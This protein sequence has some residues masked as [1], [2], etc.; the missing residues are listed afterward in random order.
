MLRAFLL[1]SLLSMG[2][3]AWTQ[4]GDVQGQLRSGGSPVAYAVVAIAGTTEATNADSTGHFRLTQVPVGAL[5]LVVMAIG[6]ETIHWKGQV[7]S[8]TPQTIF[9]EMLA[10]P[11]SMS[12]VVVTGTLKSVSKSECPLPIEI[13]SSSFFKKNP[14]ASLFES[15]QNINGVR[16]QNNCN[17]CN[18]GDIHINGLE[19]AYTLVLIDG[20]PLVSSLGSVY[21]LFGI[22]RSLIERVEVVRGPAAAL[23]GSESM[24][25][26][27]NVITKRPEAAPKWSMEFNGGTW[28]D[29]QLDLGHAAA[30]GKKWSV[31]T[32]LNYFGFDERVD[33][34]GDGFTDV[35]LQSRISVFQKWRM[36]RK[37]NR[38]FS[39]SARYYY[40]DRW[41]GEVEWQRKDRGRDTYYGESIYTNRWEC[42]GVYQLPIKEKIM[43]Q[44]SYIEHQQNS[45]Y[46]LTHF[47][48]H[49]R[50][51]LGQLTW[52]KKIG[53]WDGL[54]GVSNRYT[55][56][57]DNTTVT[58]NGD[59][60]CPINQPSIQIL[61]GVFAQTEWLK[62]ASHRL[63]LGA[64]LDYHALHG[65]IFTPR[66]AHKW[67]LP[68]K[69]ILRFNIGSGFRVVNVF[70]E[71]HAALTGARNVVV[72]SDL[73][74][75]RSTNASIAFATAYK[76]ASGL[77]ITIDLNVFYTYFQ[78]RILPDYIT[79]ANAIFYN[80]LNGHADNKGINLSV[81]GSWRD[82]WRFN[83]GITWNESATYTWHNDVLEKL[84]PFFNE[85]FAGAWSITYVSKKWPLTIDYTGNVYSPMLLPLLGPLDPRSGQSPWWSIQN[86]QMTYKSGRHW[87]WFGGVK[88]LL[89]WTPLGDNPFLI[90]LSHDPFDKQ[91]E[92]DSQGRAIATPSNPHALTFDP[93]YVYAPNQGMRLFVGVR[94]EW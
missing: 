52:D 13:Y 70:N 43:W 75:E 92:F 76:W 84:R 23:Y 58:S 35:A 22:P 9:I 27:I 86:I 30:L 25:G 82:R 16:P 55:F 53:K 38:L 11:E 73:K 24:G 29:H 47:Q 42:V 2:C 66:M 91:V 20:M 85:R 78:N 93:S 56:Y 39:F 28:L 32:G 1:I 74:P 26:L 64:R 68:S 63:L 87:E 94:W 60:L 3:S 36:Q 17:V 59:L 67:T 90:A 89:N 15:M 45:V 33:H 72:A 5:E 6:Y 12:E 61:P 83:A 80:N 50:V 40:E 69:Q 48:G 77:L 19:G 7:K 54:L 4:V 34:D 57:D 51:A 44:W 37:D 88:N 31:L 14:S 65:L 41:G 18:T 8:G 71:E 79:D 62:N 81:D 10:Q 46:G 49:Q 21:G